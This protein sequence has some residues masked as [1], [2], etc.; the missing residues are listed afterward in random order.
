VGVIL[1]IAFYAI[2]TVVWIATIKLS[3]STAERMSETH[4]VS[5]AIPLPTVIAVGLINPLFE[6]VFVCGYVMTALHRKESLWLALNVSVAIRL[7]Y[8]LYQGPLGVLSIN[9]FGLV[10]GFWYARTGRLWPVIVAH[11]IIDVVG[12]LGAR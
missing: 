1:F 10:A 8:H 9:P 2:W 7:L 4:I 6:E 12:M 11:S 3:P 5:L